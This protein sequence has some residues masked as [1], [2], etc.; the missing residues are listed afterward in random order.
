MCMGSLGRHFIDFYLGTFENENRTVPT[1][2]DIDR[3]LKF[4]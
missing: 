1:I 2:R 3:K 4:L